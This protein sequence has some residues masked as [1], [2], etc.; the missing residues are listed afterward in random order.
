M[1]SGV[2]SHSGPSVDLAIFALHLS[3]VSSLLGAMNFLFIWHVFFTG[4][5][6]PIKLNFNKCYSSLNK[7]NSNVNNNN[8]S[9]N[10]D[11]GKP[12][13]KPKLDNKWKEI[14]G[15]SGSNKHSH[16]LAIEQLNSDNIVTA[17]IINEILA[18]CNIKTTNEELR[19]LLN[20]P[21]FVLANLKKYN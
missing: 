18:Y 8:N 14:L 12:N 3:G 19:D 6:N 7:T 4:L 13:K 11:P 20:T 9:S 2:Q 5:K 10:N 16:V 17:S 21:S 1:L 15:R